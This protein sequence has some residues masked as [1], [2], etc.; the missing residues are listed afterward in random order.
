MDKLKNTLTNVVGVVLLV[1]TGIAT[2]LEAVPD[3]SGWY[4]WTLAIAGAIV[5]YF[6]GRSSE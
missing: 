1:A 6:T 3:G 4:V 2:A 5:S